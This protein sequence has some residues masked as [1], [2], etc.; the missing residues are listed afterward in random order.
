[1]GLLRMLGRPKT[2]LQPDRQQKDGW[3]YVTMLRDSPFYHD[4]T[5]L[6]SVLVFYSICVAFTLCCTICFVL[7]W[8]LVI[9]ATWWRPSEINDDDNDDCFDGYDILFRS[10]LL[11]ALTSY[12]S[13]MLFFLFFYLVKQHAHWICEHFRFQ[14]VT[15][16]RLMWLTCCPDAFLTFNEWRYKY[17]PKVRKFSSLRCGCLKNYDFELFRL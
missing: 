8:F 12:R 10:L 9:K 14:E 15:I 5:W 13:N 3:V 11:N 4:L 1:M 16:W 2:R 7:Y 17:F 6:R